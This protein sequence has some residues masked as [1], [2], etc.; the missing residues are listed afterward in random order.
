MILVDGVQ[1]GQT[2]VEFRG[3]NG[4]VTKFEQLHGDIISSKEGEEALKDFRGYHDVKVWSD[5]IELRGVKTP[6]KPLD[7]RVID[8]IKELIEK[9]KLRHPDVVRA[10]NEKAEKDRELKYSARQKAEDEAFRTKAMEALGLN[11]PNSDDS[12]IAKVIEAM[13]WAQ[14]Q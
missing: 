14:T 9:G 3:R 13:R 11:D 5:K 10:E 2:R 1:W 8:K 4:T 6:S 7:E 12:R